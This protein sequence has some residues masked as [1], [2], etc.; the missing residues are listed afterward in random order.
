MLVLRLLFLLNV[1]CM[2]AKKLLKLRLSNVQLD[3]TATT[4]HLPPVMT[5]I[6]LAQDTH[7]MLIISHQRL[8]P[9]GACDAQAVLHRQ[10]RVSLSL[11]GLLLL[12]HESPAQ[13][14]FLD[15]ACCS[16][17]AVRGMSACPLALVSP[18]A[19]PSVQRLRANRPL[20]VYCCHRLRTIRISAS[21]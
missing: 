17:F 21:C 11:A 10:G 20:Q 9:C 12:C 19:L 1:C 4:A 6:M 13:R 5:P 3:G 2:F 7:W 8:H 14:F 15:T 16:C 18:V